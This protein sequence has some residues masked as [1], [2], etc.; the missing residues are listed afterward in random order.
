[1]L[2]TTFVASMMTG[3][4]AA[5]GDLEGK[6]VVDYSQNGVNWKGECATGTEQSPINIKTK[7]KHADY[8][9]RKEGYQLRG[10]AFGSVGDSTKWSNV[11]TRSFTGFRS[12]FIRVDEST[13]NKTV[14]KNYIPTGFVIKSPSE[15]TLNGKH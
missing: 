8:V 13:G 9:V 6:T 14:V 3:Y 1:M 4:A 7:G 12:G 2:K 10:N 5:L 15:H 11:S